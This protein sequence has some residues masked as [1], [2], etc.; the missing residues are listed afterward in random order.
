MFPSLPV[1]A[2]IPT[3]R[4]S[5]CFV[6]AR[7]VIQSPVTKATALSGGHVERQ[8]LQHIKVTFCSGVSCAFCEHSL[9]PKFK[10]LI[11]PLQAF[12]HIQRDDEYGDHK[13]PR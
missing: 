3:A 5:Q 12:L 1:N 6:R 11:I 4:L 7:L 2:L 9:L 8:A 10:I 13:E